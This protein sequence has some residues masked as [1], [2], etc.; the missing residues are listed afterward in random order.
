MTLDPRIWNDG[1]GPISS[2]V[3]KV[4]EVGLCFV[5]SVCTKKA[6]LESDRQ[7]RK[8]RAAPLQG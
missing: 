1:I 2:L 8:A 3:G 4:K 6:V 5:L 7:S